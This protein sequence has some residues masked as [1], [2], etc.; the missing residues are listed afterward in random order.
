MLQFHHIPMCVSPH[1][2]VRAVASKEYKK[3]IISANS[4]ASAS[5][6]RA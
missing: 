2:Y 6:W 4:L 1:S 3:E 5:D